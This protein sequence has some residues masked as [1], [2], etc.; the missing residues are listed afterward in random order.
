MAIYPVTGPSE[1]VSHMKYGFVTIGETK[2]RVFRSSPLYG[3]MGY[4]AVT[5]DGQT[6][7]VHR[8]KK[9]DGDKGYGVVNIQKKAPKKPLRYYTQKI[10]DDLA[11][12]VRAWSSL[13]ENIKSKMKALIKT[14]KKE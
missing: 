13:T 14:Q 11:E 12:I 1:D 4:G 10:P 6:F 2:Y 9:E 3:D 8:A 7:T 5:V